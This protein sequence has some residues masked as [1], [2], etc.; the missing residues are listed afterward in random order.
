M[1]RLEIRLLAWIAL[2]PVLTGGCGDSQVDQASAE[3]EAV[4]DT[5]AK[6][7]NVEVAHLVPTPFEEYIRLTG[8]VQAE[9]DVVLSAEETGRIERFYVEKGDHVRRG[10]PLVKIDDR[11]LQ[12]MSAEAEAES[13]L[14]AQGYRVARNA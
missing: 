1:T 7:I 12:A 10:Q 5:Y 14:R 4:A 6:I 8:T 2:V 11:I 9:K 13:A 3:D